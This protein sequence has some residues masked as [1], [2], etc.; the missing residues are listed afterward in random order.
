MT[1]GHLPRTW[2]SANT[3]SSLGKMI[4]IFNKR[5]LVVPCEELEVGFLEDVASRISPPQH[6]VIAATKFFKWM[7]EFIINI[8]MD[9]R[10]HYK[11]ING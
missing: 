5:E 3:F 2:R 8:Q 7:K 10:V 4:S 1:P 11:Y 9:E 6:F